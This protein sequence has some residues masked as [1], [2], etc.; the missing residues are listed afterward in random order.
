MIPQS[1]FQAYIQRKWNPGTVLDFVDTELNR[2][3][4]ILPYWN[5]HFNENTDSKYIS[6]Q[7]ESMESHCI[8]WVNLMGQCTRRRGTRTVLDPWLYRLGKG[9]EECEFP[10]KPM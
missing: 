9:T 8:K 10:R 7:V 6:Q 1:H 4:K 5:L 3:V 2:I